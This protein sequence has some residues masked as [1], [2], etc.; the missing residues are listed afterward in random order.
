MRI[1]VATKHYICIRNC[2]NGKLIKEEPSSC[3]AIVHNYEEGR[4]YTYY[5]TDHRRMNVIYGGQAYLGYV[6]N[7]FMEENFILEKDYDS[8]LHELDKLWNNM[9]E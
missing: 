2:N 4:R 5:T 9:M 3:D 7:E 6:T 8:N 1:T